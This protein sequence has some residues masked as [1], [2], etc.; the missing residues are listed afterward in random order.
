MDS[1]QHGPVKTTAS[2]VKCQEAP[3]LGPHINE[4]E[5]K[6]FYVEEQLDIWS[7]ESLS[8]MPAFKVLESCVCSFSF[9]VLLEYTF[10]HVPFF[11]N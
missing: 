9:L 8:L 7:L 4:F 11:K 2:L 10:L 1:S 5:I 6:Q 3:P